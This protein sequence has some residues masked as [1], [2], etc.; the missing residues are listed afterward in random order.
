MVFGLD[1]FWDDDR[2]L[3]A[4]ILVATAVAIAF[5]WI[6]QYRHRIISDDSQPSGLPIMILVSRSSDRRME[7]EVID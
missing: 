1:L 6:L 2:L 5:E 3:H 7:R 4:A